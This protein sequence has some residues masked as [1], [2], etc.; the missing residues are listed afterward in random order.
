MVTGHTSTERSR[1]QSWLSV[2]PIA[3]VL[4]G[5]VI[6]LGIWWTLDR[7]EQKQANL[8]V[9]EQ[10][11][12]LLFALQNSLEQRYLTIDRMA[13]RWAAANGTPYAEWLGDAAAQYND[14]EGLESI[15]WISPDGIVTWVYPILGNEH[16][17]N[18]P[19]TAPA[20]VSTMKKAKS[21]R[22]AA[23]SPA[24]SLADGGGGFAAFSPIITDDGFAGH[25]AATFR[26]D[27]VISE[28][29]SDQLTNDLS[30][31]IFQDSVLVWESEAHSHP[32]PLYDHSSSS[33]AEIGDST[34]VIE[35]F[36]TETMLARNQSAL[37]PLS[38]L[39][40]AVLSVLCALLV[41]FGILS[42]DRLYAI[43]EKERRMELVVDTVVDAL[44]TINTNGTIRTFNP[45]A[46]RMFGY[47]RAEVLGEN[48]KL[49]MPD[50][51]HENHDDY[52]KAY[53]TTGRAAI[54]GR[55]REVIARKKD[56]AT[57]PV[58]L[59]IGEFQSGDDHLFTG[60]IRD[61]SERHEIERIQKEFVSVV[62]HE[63]RTPV[64][65]I[66][67]SLKLLDGGLA[68]KLP[69]EAGSMLSIALN[70]SERLIRLIN[71]ILDLE[72]IESG[73]VQL[74]RDPCDLGAIVSQ[75]LEENR[76]YADRFAVALNLAKTVQGQ[77]TVI[78]DP[79][80][81]AQVL[82]NLISN[83]VKHSS[84]GGAVDVTLEAHSAGYQIAVTDYGT[85]IPEN[86]QDRVF[87][88]FQQADSSDTRQVDG[89]G[90][91]L[92]ITKAIVE[93]HGGHIGFDSE[94]GEK[95]RFWVDLPIDHQ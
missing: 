69:D 28:V 9:T 68:G 24:I 53:L 11:Q 64:T 6:T 36:P 37:T 61:L 63:L 41:Y 15:A 13:R 16:Q 75:S 10:A 79:D 91:G 87:L 38:I 66:I 7:Q 43:R 67:G 34:W 95:T 84:T 47:T 51:D 83:A 30:I 12:S 40:G 44:V 76:A 21:R 85:G 92:T 50:P 49:L 48:V 57:F 32:H 46:E 5:S 55:S 62:S 89:S 2:A 17:L 27:D 74:R 3:V 54:I 80:R 29:V 42:R 58:E 20:L 93:E 33:Q 18:K 25:I 39:L 56:G 52:L 71:D 72:K 22:F 19:V 23:S 88:K 73:R 14:Q 77:A 90:L 31:H 86:F 45:A 70:N 78:G 82:N 8:L 35:A 1:R 81:L 60:I 4:L 65:S 59:S 26:S 94:P